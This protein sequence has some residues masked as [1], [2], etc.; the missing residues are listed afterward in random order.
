MHIARDTPFAESSLDLSCGA[1]VV[2]NNIFSRRN[3]TEKHH[4]CINHHNR[5]LLILECR[6]MMRRRPNT[7]RDDS[8]DPLFSLDTEE[9]V[10]SG[11]RMYPVVSDPPSTARGGSRYR[12]AMASP[13]KEHGSWEARRVSTCKTT[14]GGGYV[15]SMLLISSAGFV[16][17]DS[18]ARYDCS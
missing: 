14:I 3:P 5:G 6:A 15:L 8:N 16:S 1:G 11:S 9:K 10:A 12:S 4:T 2:K 7:S 18:S 17:G 13:R